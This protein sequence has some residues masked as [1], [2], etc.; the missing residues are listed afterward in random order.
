MP[1]RRSR[2]S[3]LPALDARAGNP[4]VDRRPVHAA[5]RPRA[6]AGDAGARARRAERGRPPAPRRRHLGRDAVQAGRRLDRRL[7]L[8][9]DLREPPRRGARAPPPARRG[10]PDR[11]TP[12][13]IEHLPAAINAVYTAAVAAALHPVFQTAAAV[14]IVAFALSWRLRDVPLRETSQAPVEASERALRTLAGS[15]ASDG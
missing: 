15:S 14:M 11:R 4:D 12:A 3:R 8:R 10:R 13:A 1:A 9:R 7:R 2:R 6:R 5:P